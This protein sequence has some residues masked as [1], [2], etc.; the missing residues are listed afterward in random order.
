MKERHLIVAI[1]HVSVNGT[2][3]ATFQGNQN[4]DPKT[5]KI[6]LVLL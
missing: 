6:G 2:T 3:L 5:I 4:E 1:Q